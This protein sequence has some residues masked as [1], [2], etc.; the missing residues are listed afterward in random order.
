MDS[1]P[2]L[3][4]GWKAESGERIYAGVRSDTRRATRATSI[5]ASPERTSVAD[6]G[7]AV[8]LPKAGK[9]PVEPAN[10]IA[11]AAEIRTI[12]IMRIARNTAR[13]T[14]A[15]RFIKIRNPRFDPHCGADVVL[16]N[17]RPGQQALPA[18]AS[19]SSSGRLSRISDTRADAV[20]TWFRTTRYAPRASRATRVDD[21]PRQSTRM[22]AVPSPTLPLPVTSNR[23]SRLPFAQFLERRPKTLRSR[24]MCERSLLAIVSAIGE[25]ILPADFRLMFTASRVTLTW[26]Q[27]RPLPWELQGGTREPVG[28]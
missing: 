27:E 11:G 15:P 22:I 28:S 25:S 4:P 7:T 5:S 3:V 2:T 19:T 9:N 18:A 21:E 16:S 13:N 23:A 24:Q 10:S 6:S 14:A 26:F 1:C 20:S 8:R 17:P 12:T